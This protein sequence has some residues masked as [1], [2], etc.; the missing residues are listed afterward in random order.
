MVRY[1]A[2]FSR[3][4]VYAYLL[5]LALMI[6]F[7]IFVYRLTAET[8]ETQMANKCAGIAV[9]T[10]TMIQQNA[11]AYREF[12]ETLDTAGDYYNGIKRSMEEI[13]RGNADNI[14][15]LYTEKRV[16]ETEMM[17]VLDGEPEGADQFSPP[18][19]RDLLTPTRRAAYE[20][21]NLVKGRFVTTRYGTLLSAYAPIRDPA[22]GQLLGLVGVD[23]S[24]YQY[25][26]IMNYLLAV[27]VVSVGA[28]VV[29]VALVLVLSSSRVERLITTDGLTGVYNKASFL[30]SLKRQAKTA[31]KTGE[32]LLV[33]MADLDHFKNVNDTYGHQFGDKVLTGVAKAI[34]SVLRESD[35]L[36]RYGGEEFSAYFPGATTRNAM[37]MLERI[38]YSVEA[39]K[40]RNPETGEDIGVTISIGAS[41]LGANQTITEAIEDADKALYQAKE[42]RNA[43]V[44]S[45]GEDGNG[46]SA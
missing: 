21:G 44:I 46:A 37:L 43:V 7:G 30:G 1:G 32:P 23:V 28:M 6:A 17:F 3:I 33:M 8:V 9:A 19:E 34:K 14:I 13:R 29:L 25:Y 22:D 16:S 35:C 10:A 2:V 24:L 5:F 4:F 41:Y 27:I 45:T 18:G 12:S 42:N 20:S 26:G 39:L 31:R 11:P 38:R 36:A 15:F 40:V